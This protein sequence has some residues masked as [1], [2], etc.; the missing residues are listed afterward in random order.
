MAVNPVERLLVGGA[1]L[2]RLQPHYLL[3]IAQWQ[4]IVVQVYT[5]WL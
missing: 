5:Y 4:L 2:L 1:L 3:C